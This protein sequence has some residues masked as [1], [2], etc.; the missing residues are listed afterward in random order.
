MNVYEV[1]QEVNG[2]LYDGDEDMFPRTLLVVAEVLY[3][4]KPVDYFGWITRGVARGGFDQLIIE[5]SGNILDD[6][7]EGMIEVHDLFIDEGQLSVDISE[8]VRIICVSTLLL[9][10]VAVAIGCYMVS[11]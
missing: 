8:G 4:L 6:S 9:G 7:L 1:A 10:A 11:R 3:A 2:R 5:H